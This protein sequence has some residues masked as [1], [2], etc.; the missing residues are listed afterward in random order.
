MNLIDRNILGEN[1]TN[2]MVH[3][4]DI[5]NTP[6]VDVNELFVA[7]LEKVK[8][9]IDNH[10]QETLEMIGDCGFCHGLDKA[11]EYIDKELSELKGE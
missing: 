2:G 10:K 3:W 9:K 11:I 6:T 1:I 4:E 8:T 5:M 7:E